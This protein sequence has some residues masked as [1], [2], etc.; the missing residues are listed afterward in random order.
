MGLQVKV[1]FQ[2][3]QAG[4]GTRINFYSVTFYPPKIP[5]ELFC[6][7]VCCASL[8]DHPHTSKHEK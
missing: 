2:D 5:T 8:R 7:L 4:K 1:Y 3:E 6:P